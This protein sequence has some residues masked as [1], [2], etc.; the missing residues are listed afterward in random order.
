MKR[1]GTITAVVLFLA[2]F[3]AAGAYTYGVHLESQDAFCASCHT[4]PES[5]YYQQ[6][7]TAEPSTLA[8]FHSAKDTRCIDCH[9]EKGFTGRLKAMVTGARDMLAYRTGRYQQPAKTTRPLGND[10]CTKCHVMSTFPASEEAINQGPQ[11]HYHA[12][13]LNQAWQQW[14]GPINT[15]TVCHPAH[16]QGDPAQGF[17]TIAR[18]ERGC[19]MCHN[20]LG[21]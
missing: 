17:T 18:V 13:A 16:R 10:S 15:C 3:A 14:G 5:T 12:T 6:T 20:V 1:I 11:S 4:E 9:S 19:Q 7:Q 2:L 21:E 8:A